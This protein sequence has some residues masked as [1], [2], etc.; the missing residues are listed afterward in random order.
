M[1]RAFGKYVDN[2]TDIPMLNWNNDTQIKS[3]ILDDTFIH[4]VKFIEVT[5]KK[6][7]LK[8]QM[9]KINVYLN[10]NKKDKE[11]EK[12][13]ERYIGRDIFIC[14][15]FWWSIY[16]HHFKNYELKMMHLSEQLSNFTKELLLKK[17]KKRFQ[18]LEQLDPRSPG[19]PRVSKVYSF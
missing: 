12:Y 8:S 10:C 16:A 5:W 2:T 14:D 9:R 19:A 3:I 15:L 13:W 17:K 1:I 18:F 6:L 7:T 4:I 11:E